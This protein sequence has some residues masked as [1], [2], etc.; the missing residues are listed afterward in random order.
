MTDLGWLRGF[1]QRSRLV[2]ANPQ[3]K[4]QVSHGEAEEGACGQR[5]FPL[6]RLPSPVQQLHHHQQRKPSL[7]RRASSYFNNN[8]GS[9]GGGGRAAATP[10]PALTTA[11]AKSDDDGELGLFWRECDR[12]WVSH[13]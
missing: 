7:L 10:S 1:S 4:S 13:K 5:P 2:S 9:G 11:T 6:P 12:T 8:N 3:F